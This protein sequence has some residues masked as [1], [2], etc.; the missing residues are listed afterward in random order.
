MFCA[1]KISTK[2]L[3]IQYKRTEKSVQAKTPKTPLSK[4]IFKIPPI[5]HS[6]LKNGAQDPAG[7]ELREQLFP[8][9]K[10]TVDLFVAR[11]AAYAH[12]LTNR[13]DRVAESAQEHT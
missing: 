3:R 7:A 11:V 12:E 2:E 13:G 9:G 6:Y 8:E 5:I 10:P 1:K 4:V